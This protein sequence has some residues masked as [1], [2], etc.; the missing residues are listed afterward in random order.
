MQGRHAGS[1]QHDGTPEREVQERAEKGGEAERGSRHGADEP[2]DRRAAWDER[3]RSSGPIESAAPHPLLVEEVEGLRPG[4]ALDLATGDGTNATWLAARGWR[5]T[6]VDFSP[7]ALERGRRLAADLG[8]EIN[9]VEADLHEYRPLAR[10]FDLVTILYL[11]VPPD[12]RHMI[13]RA[14]AEAVAPGGTILIIGHDRTNLD[15][16]VGGPRD[17]EVL[18]TPAEVAADLADLAVER[19]E[20]VR[21]GGLGRVP[22]DALVLA[23]RER[24]RQA[25]ARTGSDRRLEDR[26]RLRRTVPG[27][28]QLHEQPAT[29]RGTTTATS[30]TM[31][32]TASWTRWSRGEVST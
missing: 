21:R 18:F 26:P 1:H 22:I 32:V 6:A 4:M 20:V 2:M 11:H 7:V 16:G 23:R 28:S 12:E 30:P 14:A 19:A 15:H 25:E 8:V 17:P 29:D 5:V 10:A 9:W 27:A 24:H 3:H 13:Y 31:E